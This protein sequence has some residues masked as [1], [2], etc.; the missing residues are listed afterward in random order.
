MGLEQLLGEASASDLRQ[1]LDAY[2]ALVDSLAEDDLEPIPARAEVLARAARTL[3]QQAKEED[4]TDLATAAGRVSAAAEVSDLRLAS[5]LERARHGLG[6]VSQAMF[7]LL[8]EP[9][10]PD[11]PG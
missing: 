3:A 8:A 9:R 10:R 6:Q 11:A 7:A 5:D 1:V 2:F 4:R